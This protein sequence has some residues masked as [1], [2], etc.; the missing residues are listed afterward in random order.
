MVSMPVLNKNGF[1]FGTFREDKVAG[2]ESRLSVSPKVQRSPLFSADSTPRSVPEIIEPS[3][4]EPADV[5]SAFPYASVSLSCSKCYAPGEMKRVYVQECS[6]S[7]LSHACSICGDKFCD[8]PMIK[9]VSIDCV[10]PVAHECESCGYRVCI[11]C[12]ML[13]NM[14]KSVAEVDAKNASRMSTMQ[15]EIQNLNDKLL[16]GS[17]SPSRA[18]TPGPSHSTIA[19]SP[20]SD[21]L[22]SFKD[23]LIEVEAKLTAEKRAKEQLSA[24]LNSLQNE[25]SQY[26]TDVEMHL[27]SNAAE[28]ILLQSRLVEQ[29]VL[30]ADAR[31]RIDELTSVQRREADGPRKSSSSVLSQ[32]EAILINENNRLKEEVDLLKVS[33]HADFDNWKRTV[34]KQVKN[35][36][37]RYRSR[38]Q[39]NLRI[40]SADPVSGDPDENEKELDFLFDE[41]DWTGDLKDISPERVR[42]PAD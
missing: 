24:L 32:R 3:C 29:S 23:R 25:Y 31:A 8:S 39:K 34:L 2:K 7:I 13:E 20:A 9:C 26:K 42:R 22:Q 14:Q 40:E 33:M 35:E 16:V 38:L 30:L 11:K 1:E 15:L 28:Q 41:V 4:S 17:L 10:T 19:Q 12:N 6:S 37:L 21:V 27:E 36:C 5:V 18:S